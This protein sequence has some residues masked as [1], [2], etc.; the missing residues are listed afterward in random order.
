MK[1]PT[2]SF[3]TLRAFFIVD[4]LVRGVTP[5]E[6]RKIVDHKDT[7]TMDIYIEK[8]KSIVPSEHSTDVLDEIENPRK[9]IKAV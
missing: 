8:A 9:R 7:K 6:V 3:H 1:I 2:T 4:M 5:I